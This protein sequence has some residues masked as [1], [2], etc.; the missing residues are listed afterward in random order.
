MAD[1]RGD[2]RAALGW[3]GAWVGRSMRA[4]LEGKGSGRERKEIGR[5]HV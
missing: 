3:I 4:A 5:A 2:F 1:Y